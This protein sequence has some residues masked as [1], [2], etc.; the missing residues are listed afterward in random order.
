MVKEE[1]VEDLSEQLV[2]A[3]EVW[4]H[5]LKYFQWYFR[6]S[7]LFWILGLLNN[8]GKPRKIKKKRQFEIE[9]KNFWKKLKKGV[10]FSESLVYNNYCLVA[11][12]KKTQTKMNKAPWSSGQD[13]SLSR[14]NQGFDSPRSHW[15]RSA[16]CSVDLFFFLI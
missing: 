9:I 16:E 2:E 3:E 7:P 5:N 11:V 8:R 4:T 12:T 6:K 10:A 13:A 15:W 14:W 1:A